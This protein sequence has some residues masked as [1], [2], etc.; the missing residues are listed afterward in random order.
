MFD[1]QG[2]GY[3]NEEGVLTSQL[4][5]STLQDLQ[6]AL[7]EQLSEQELSDTQSAFKE[8][9]GLTA[10]DF[11]SMRSLSELLGKVGGDYIL[12]IVRDDRLYN[13]FQPIVAADEET[14][15]HGH[16][17]L[18]R[19]ED[20]NGDPISPGKLFG[21]A[22][23]G[24]MMFELDR[25]ARETAV[26]SGS[27]LPVN[28]KIFINFVPTSIYDPDYCLK[29]TMEAIEEHEV[30]REQLVF[31]VVETEEVED[32]STLI[33]ILD[34][35]RQSGVNVA[36]DDLGAGY[37]SLNMLKDLNPD[38]IK[39]DLELVQAVTENDVQAEIARGLIEAAKKAGITTIAEGIEG[40]AEKQW[41]QDAGV[42]F[43][44]G[45]FFA[46]PS[47]EPRTEFDE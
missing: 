1:D 38:Y 19:A 27:A 29:T 36:L 14:T 28:Q 20:R 44:Q 26:K 21:D 16:E 2:V 37:S 33:D 40:K 34:E 3:E 22:E 43:M 23:R 42:D 32:R 5:T 15:V 45:Y 35:Y 7:N 25:A 4:T 47:R 13:V 9:E 10:R 31:E 8:D 30:R 6:P 39:L 41:F 24:N 18:V 17:L 11:T 12:D 46:K